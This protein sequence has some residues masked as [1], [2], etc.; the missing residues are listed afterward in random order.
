MIGRTVALELEPRR[1]CRKGLRGVTITIS[2][3]PGRFIIWGS[4]WE[5]GGSLSIA[6]YPA[7]GP[8]PVDI[9]RHPGMFHDLRPEE[10][11]LATRWPV[12]CCRPRSVRREAS[13]D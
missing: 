7:A 12:V 2:G 11:K 1:G 13:N 4:H 6:A 10:C 9:E 8:K 3:R 5:R